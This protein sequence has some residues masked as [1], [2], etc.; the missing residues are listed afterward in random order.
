LVLAPGRFKPRLRTGLAAAAIPHNCCCNRKA[1][2]CCC[3][4]SELAPS[5]MGFEC[6]GSK[7]DGLK[8]EDAAAMSYKLLRDGD[9][10][11]GFDGAVC[12]CGD[13]E[14]ALKRRKRCSMRIQKNESTNTQR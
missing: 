14:A 7:R 5:G 12:N 3:C 13:K 10:C 11:D 6:P 1:N 4:G 9:N 8:N 2:C